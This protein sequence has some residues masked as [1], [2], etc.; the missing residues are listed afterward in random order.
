[1]V[2]IRGHYPNC[3]TEPGFQKP[4]LY[5]P[6]LLLNAAFRLFIVNSLISSSPCTQK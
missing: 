4:E 6:V 2:Y 5:K 3:N 1:M